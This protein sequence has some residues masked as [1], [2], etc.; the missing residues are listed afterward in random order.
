MA[1]CEYLPPLNSF[2]GLFHLLKYLQL[3]YMQNTILKHA[4]T[5]KMQ[6]KDVTEQHVKCAF[7]LYASDRPAGPLVAIATWL[8]LNWLNWWLCTQLTCTLGQWTEEL[9]LL[10]IVWAVAFLLPRL[11]TAHH[12]T[13]GVHGEPG[14]SFFLD[15]HHPETAEGHWQHTRA[16]PRSGG[17]TQ[18]DGGEMP[19]P[20]R[21]TSTCLKPFLNTSYV[22]TG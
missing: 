19:D 10:L 9:F 21:I 7:S 4:R 15:T 3:T 6:S 13:A 18:R 17:P 22:G 2:S 14:G 20:L 8:V 1:V 5:L 11:R 12:D 16:P